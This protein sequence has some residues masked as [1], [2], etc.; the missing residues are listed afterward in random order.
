M[1]LDLLTIL[2]CV[3]VSWCLYVEN[4]NHESGAYLKVDTTL[5]NVAKVPASS[6]KEPLQINVQYVPIPAR[7]SIIRL[8]LLSCQVRKP[9]VE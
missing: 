7:E 9:S 2:T 6:R 8:T 4:V 5:Q 3:P 1:R